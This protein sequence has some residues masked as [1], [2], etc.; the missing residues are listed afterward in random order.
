M[1]ALAAVGAWLAAAPALFWTLE[2]AERMAYERRLAATQVSDVRDE[3]I[4]RAG[5]PVGVRLSFSAVVP[6]RGYFGIIPT[7]YPRDERMRQLQLVSLRWRFDGRPG[8]PDFGPFEP[9]RKHQLEFEL[10]PPILSINR[11]GV[12]CLNPITP[13][14]LPATA[15]GLLLVDISDSP[16]GAPWRGG[17]EEATR[18]AYDVAAM[19]RALLAEGLPTCKVPGQ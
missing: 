2:R 19:Y 12:R 18:N 5:T 8:P 1:K 17:R 10:Y 16:Y 11:E 6:A 4:L 13:P 15:S 7:L 3:P 14:P 9:E